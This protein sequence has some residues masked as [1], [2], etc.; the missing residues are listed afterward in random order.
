MSKTWTILEVLDWT[1]QRFGQA[2][3][4]AARLDA[5]LLLV[6]VLQIERIQLYTQFDKPL[7]EDELAAYRA[8]IR[9]RLDGEPVAYILGEKEFWSLPLSVDPRVLVPRPDTELLVE[10][11]LEA[12]R[13]RGGACRIVDL[14]TGSGAV[15][16]ALA[17]ELSSAEVIATD[18]SAAA[19]EVAG[20][21]AARHGVELAF[22]QGDLFEPLAGQTFDIAVANP[23]Y[24]PSG[25]IDGLA[26][27]VRAEPRLALDGGADGLDL[28]RRL[29]DAAPNHLCSGG[30]LALEHGFDQAAA[31]RALFDG[32]GA[33]F[34]AGT[35]KDLAGHPRVTLATRR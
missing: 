27:E 24:I 19:V 34:P 10:V 35:R 32:A 26:R 20:A 5:E 18:V 31:V 14:C 8:R 11:A 12:A 15:A 1:K 6:D 23:P 29:I 17:T 22:V 13:E 21:N 16:V 33:Y 2:G 30:V 7:A 4:D 3:I 25:D 28:V 9:R